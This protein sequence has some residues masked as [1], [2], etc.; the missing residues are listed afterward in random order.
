MTWGKRF[1]ELVQRSVPTAGL[2]MK[3]AVPWPP[4]SHTGTMSE[5]LS[6]PW[7]WWRGGVLTLQTKGMAK[8]SSPRRVRL[9][10]KRMR[11]RIFKYLGSSLLFFFFVMKEIQQQFP[12]TPPTNACDTGQNRACTFQFPSKSDLRVRSLS[13]RTSWKQGHA[14]A[15]T[16]MQPSGIE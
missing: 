13:R 1:K 9:G 3:A 14:Q 11:P 7:R 5:K 4:G 6:A 10:N 2:K 16:A 8:P 12:R 15:D